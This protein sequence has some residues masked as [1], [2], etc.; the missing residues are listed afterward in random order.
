MIRLTVLSGVVCILGVYAWK[1]WYKAVCGL[2][3]LMAFLEHP[4]MPRTIFGIQGLN[5]WNLLL[6]SIILGWMA[7]QGSERLT[8]DLPRAFSFLLIAFLLVVTTAFLRLVEDRGALVR[9][10]S[11]SEAISEYL[12]NPVKFIV[13]GLLLFHGCRSR[14]RLY[15]G[16]GSI[17]FLYV[18]LSL[19]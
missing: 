8:W 15:W 12:V 14:S 6:L 17:L 16:L 4:D 5:L 11:L 1:D 7:Q 2:V 9:A 18:F 10:S 3:V 19:Q 13:P